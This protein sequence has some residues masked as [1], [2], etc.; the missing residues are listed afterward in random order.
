[1]NCKDYK[2]R[3]PEFTKFPLSETAWDS[4]DY[5]SWREHG[6]ECESYNQWNLEQQVIKRGHNPT[7]Y[8]CAHIAY[9]STMPC[10]DHDDPWECPDMNIVKTGTVYGIPI[11]DGGT[12]YLKINN[13]P[14]CGIKL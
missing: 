12:S 4:E 2:K 13:C 9:H 3:Y 1:M 7:E 5:E 10:E 6:F 8:P 11:R 14:W